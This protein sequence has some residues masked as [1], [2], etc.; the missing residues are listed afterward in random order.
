LLSGCNRQPAPSPTN[1]NTEVKPIV[2]DVKNTN[3]EPLKPAV[4][5]EPLKT[6]A[7]AKLS[8]EKEVVG[9]SE[10]PKII[11]LKDNLVCYSYRK[12]AVIVSP[13]DEVGED[14]KVI[15]KL[16]A[17]DESFLTDLKKAPIYYKVPEGE[18]LLRHL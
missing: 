7:G 8:D 2:G 10:A 11:K 15:A 13:T 4:A 5:E 17:S 16:G 9:N 1:Q 18:I 3:S 12:Y 14:I 6:I